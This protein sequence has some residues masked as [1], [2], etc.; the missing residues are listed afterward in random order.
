MRLS[1]FLGGGRNELKEGDP[2]GWEWVALGLG[3]LMCSSKYNGKASTLP[4]ITEFTV[5]V[6][7]AYVHSSYT[8]QIVEIM[9]S[10]G[11]HTFV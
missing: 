3:L 11:N 7:Y 6:L 5:S 8:C 10:I 1:L 9:A 4:Y 2:G